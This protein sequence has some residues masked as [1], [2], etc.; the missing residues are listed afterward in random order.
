MNKFASTER[1]NAFSR[2]FASA[3]A[4]AGL[5]AAQGAVAQTPD[6]P[7]A[8]PALD[9]NGVDLVTGQF[10]HQGATVSI[11]QPGA[12]G[13]SYSAGSRT[14]LVLAGRQIGGSIRKI[15]SGTFSV[16]LG[17]R[18][19]RFIGG[20]GGFTPLNGAGDT[21]TYDSATE[22]YTYTAPDGFVAIY[23][24]DVQNS[25]PMGHGPD[26]ADLISV[27][28]PNGETA[29]LHYKVAVAE[30]DVETGHTEKAQRLQSITNEYGYM[31]HFE[32]AYNDDRSSVTI[33]LSDAWRDLEKITAINTAVD[34]CWRTDDICTGLTQN[35]PTLT[36]SGGE[37][38]DSLNRALNYSYDAN[39]RL[40][41][42]RWPGSSADNISLTWDASGRVASVD[43]GFGTWTYLYF[44]A[45]DTRTT[46]VTDPT[47]AQTVV[48]STISTGRIASIRD[49]LNRTTSYQY[50]AQDRLTRVTGPEGDYV[51]YAYDSRG[52]VTQTTW[53]PKSGAS[54]ADITTSAT[55]PASCSNP[56]TCNKPTSTTDARGKVTDYTYDPDHGGVLTVTAPAPSPGAA[57]PRRAT[58]TASTARASKTARRAM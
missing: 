27:A 15:G 25:E 50:D 12:G 40:T 36:K 20:S 49:A 23:D 48:T 29:T 51:Q 3:F 26:D 38:R 11:G 46:T 52:N 57:R 16:S 41:G 7:P 47:G 9:G 34:Y 35:W 58:P 24:D 2:L 54:L 28:A 32:Y 22:L 43:R 33:P 31:I 14:V 13:L 39:G 42:V 45:G 4:L 21:L 30:F 56:L 18:S 10:E 8:F 1:L 44:E 53:A 6:V 19:V 37:W 55:F 17:N 5:A